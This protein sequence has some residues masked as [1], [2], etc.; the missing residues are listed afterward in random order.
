MLRATTRER[1]MIDWIF[2]Q[3]Q[4]QKLIIYT[5]RSYAYGSYITLNRT[6]QHFSNSSKVDSLQRL[7]DAQLVLLPTQIPKQLLQIRLSFFTR[8][9]PGWT[10]SYRCWSIRTYYKMTTSSKAV[11]RTNLITPS[12]FRPRCVILVLLKLNPWEGTAAYLGEQAGTA[13]LVWRGDEAPVCEQHGWQH[14]PAQH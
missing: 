6:H 11:I 12:I 13:K 7:I 9:L 10:R 8:F 5:P 3:P 1:M 14:S 2:T 4:R